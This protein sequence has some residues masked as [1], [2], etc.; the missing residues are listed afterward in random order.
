MWTL[1]RDDVATKPTHNIQ[2]KNFMFTVFWSPP[3]LLVVDE[4]ASGAKIDSDSFITNVG[5]QLE[6]KMFP[7][8][9]S[10][11]AKRLTV[12]LDNCSVHTSG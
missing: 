8:G 7:Y 6:R 5:A 2:T 12:Y 9:R 4:L 10:P 3:A 1:T 11:H